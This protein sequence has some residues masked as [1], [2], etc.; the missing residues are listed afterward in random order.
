MPEHQRFDSTVTAPPR[1]RSANSALPWWVSAIVVVGALLLTMGAV[2]ALAN[3]AMLVGNALDIN[4]A[5][6]VYTGYLFSRNLAIAALLL[7]ALLTG[8]RRALIYGM[9]LTA[10]IQILD[11]AIDCI[12]GRWTIVP[13]VV[14]LGIVFLIGAVHASSN[15]IWKI[16]SWRDPL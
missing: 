6:R 14:V 7:G 15:P 10:V 3:P 9:V 8:A 1:H 16:H 4:Q 2:I 11:G 5:T 13:G 12:E